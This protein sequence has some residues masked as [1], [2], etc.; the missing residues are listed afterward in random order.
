M[1]RRLVLA[2]GLCV[3]SLSSASA[4]T[5][6]DDPVIAQVGTQTVTASEFVKAIAA[7]DPELRRKAAGDHQALLEIARSELGREAILAQARAR[8][9]DKRPDVAARAEHARDD[10]VITSFLAAEVA[11]PASFPSDDAVR[12]VYQANLSRFMQPRQYHVAQIYIARPADNKPEEVAL[13]RAHAAKL[14][15]AA[16]APGADFA[17]LAAKSSEDHD[18]APRGGDLGWVAEK[19]LLPEIARTVAGLADDE[20]SDPVEVADGWHILRE[21]GTRPPTPEPLE[22]VRPTI[23][24]LLRDQESTRLGQAYVGDLLARGHAEVDLDAVRALLAK[25]R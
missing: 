20:V 22:Q 2:L 1:I 7:L 12:Q 14:V 19:L 13:A 15:E 23:V 3:L 8:R 9:W 5:K 17:A 11:P 25:Q 18:S 4:I 21:L 10:V 16:R 24:A 6:T